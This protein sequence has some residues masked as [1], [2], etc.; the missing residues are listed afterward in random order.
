MF[1]ITS[2]T[3]AK[4]VVKVTDGQSEVVENTPG[5]ITIETTNDEAGRKAITEFFQSSKYPKKFSD[6]IEVQRRERNKI[7]QDKKNRKRNG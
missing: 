5:Q 2:K 3:P 4:I 1:N 7:K 6:R